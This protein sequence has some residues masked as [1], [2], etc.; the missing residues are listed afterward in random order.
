MTKISKQKQAQAGFTLV[1][2]S[3]VL[4]II[5][6][7]V[8]GVLVGQ[9]MIKAA[10]IRATVSQLEEYNSAV[11]TFRDKFG[12]LPGDMGQAKALQFG[13][14]DGGNRAA[15]GTDQDGRL[16]CNTAACNSAVDF[17]N[18]VPCF[19]ADLSQARMLPRV[20]D[21]TDSDVGGG[22]AG[23]I[24]PGGAAGQDAFEYMP[25]AE[26]GRGNFITVANEQG[27]NHFYIGGITSID[28]SDGQ[29]TWQDAMT[30][31]EAFNID[32]KIDDGAATTGVVQPF[33]GIGTTG[34]AVTQG[35]VASGE[36]VNDGTTTAANADSYLTETEAGSVN[37]CMYTSRTLQL[38]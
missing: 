9:D 15:N 4:V 33:E 7:I 17:G 22:A 25:E 27:I 12:A 31:Q 38:I 1:E 13:F 2:L 11:N 21:T 35:D 26:L 32:D 34:A 10:E 24:T 37:A 30:P 19:W 36:C 20:Y 6:L 8:G 28:E 29:Y 16:E 3:I 5:G 14:I 23:P 18:E